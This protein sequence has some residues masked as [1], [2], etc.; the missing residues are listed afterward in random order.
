MEDYEIIKRIKKYSGTKFNIDEITV[1][2]GEKEFKSE[3]VDRGNCIAAIVYNTITK[4]YIFVEQ[5]RAGVD[6]MM[7]EV[8]A[9]GI[10]KG[11][12]PQE[13]VK[14]EIAEEIGYKVDTINHITDCYLS[15]GGS[16]EIMALFYVEVS[17]KIGEGGGIEDEIINVIEVDELGLNG[18]IFTN[19]SEDGLITPPYRLIDA[20]SIMAVNYVVQTNMMKSLWGTL[21]DYKMKSL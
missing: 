20:K 11:E 3:V 5:Y 18:S 19:V 7:V 9:G 10:E 16:T 15:P 4:K 1:K 6:G 14:R 8:V 21:S 2:F 13:A 12:N 17:E